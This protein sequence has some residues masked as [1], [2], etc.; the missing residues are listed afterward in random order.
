M[1][2]NIQI[3]SDDPSPGIA[4]WKRQTKRTERG[5]T[6]LVCHRGRA[7]SG[8]TGLDLTSPGGGF[9]WLGYAVAGAAGFT[10]ALIFDPPVS[11]DPF[12]SRLTNEAPLAVDRAGPGSQS[13]GGARQGRFRRETHL[14]A[15]RGR[16]AGP[17]HP[18]PAGP[19]PVALANSRQRSTFHVTS[20]V[21]GRGSRRAG[22][23]P[24]GHR[25]HGSGRLGQPGTGHAGRNNGSRCGHAEG[26]GQAGDRSRL[27]DARR[28]QET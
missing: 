17:A 9:L 24:A 26:V 18:G 13:P 21:P 7:A 8:R 5:L 6:V 16:G 23:L 28:R 11:R 4:G 14:R 3:L 25:A 10:V 27:L 12:M 20:R 22:R 19:A 1:Q 15:V 2:S